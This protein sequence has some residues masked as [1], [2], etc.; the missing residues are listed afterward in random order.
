MARLDAN[1][2]IERASPAAPGNKAPWTL[3]A[4]ATAVPPG[5]RIERFGRRI[6]LCAEV[7]LRNAADPDTCWIEAGAQGW[8]FLAP[9]GRRRAV[10][11]A[12]FPE[13]PERASATALA[14]MVGTMPRIASLV[15]DLETPV[16]L[17]R[18][19]PAVR[20]PL[21]GDEWLALG[22][23]AMALD[24]ICGDGTGQALRSGLLAAAVVTALAE[25][26]DRTMLVA[27]FTRRLVRSFA[28]HLAACSQ[29]YQPALFG[30]SWQREI[31]ETQAAAAA[32]AF[33]RQTVQEFA[34]QNLRLV[35]I[36]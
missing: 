15:A 31:A 8:V 33:A 12:A 22:G 23:T 27:H 28:A 29:F 9:L 18:I 24:P 13:A 36:S 30:P 19:A 25:G 20:D 35:P 16:Q 32:F 34:L 21:A 1:C 14:E 2:S 10:V 11:Q 4:A 26:G 7:A 17:H 6:M 3:C 5:S